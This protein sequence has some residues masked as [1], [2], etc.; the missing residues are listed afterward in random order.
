M[1]LAEA[2]RRISERLLE[3]M[4]DEPGAD[5]REA[6]S[7]LDDRVRQE[8]ALDDE[9]VVPELGVSLAD[10]ELRDLGLALEEA[11]LSGAAS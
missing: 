1:G 6:M 3:Q 2:D 9:V 5:H 7:E 10:D 4:C 11:R 8:I